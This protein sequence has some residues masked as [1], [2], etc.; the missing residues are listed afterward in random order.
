MSGCDTGPCNK[1]SP[2]GLR[3]H[4]V[5]LSPCHQTSVHHPPDTRQHKY[6]EA[7]SSY[8]N[9]SSSFWNQFLSFCCW[10][11]PLY[12]C[13]SNCAKM[14]INI[15][16]R[17]L[18]FS[19]SIKTYSILASESINTLENTYFIFLATDDYLLHNHYYFIIKYLNLN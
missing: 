9:L 10:D 6:L 17:F 18:L 19:G 11:Q 4:N 1:S 12:D 3:Y 2:P 15:C 7:G 16:N 8:C 14:S 13:I 5:M